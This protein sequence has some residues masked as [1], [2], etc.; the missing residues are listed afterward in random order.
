M[1]KFYKKWFTA[2]ALPAVF[3]FILV[4]LIPF[5]MGVTYSFTAWRGTYFA[6]GNHWWQAFTG[7]KNY[8]GI[9]KKRQFLDAFFYTIK[10]TAISVVMINVAGLSLALMVK[11]IA[12]G[13]GFFRSVFFLPNLLG[14]LALGFVWQFI[15]QNVYSQ[16]LF[17]PNG[18]LPI[19][20]LTNMTQNSTKALFAFAIMAVWQSAGYMMIIYLTGLNN[21][22]GELYEASAIDGAG[23]WH[24]FRNITVPLLMPSFTVVFFLTLSQSFKM[25][26]QNVAL[27]N[28]DFGTRML[29]LQILKTTSDTNPP[30]Y[31]AAQ[32]Q[33]V[34]FFILIAT[35]SLVQVYFTKKKEVEA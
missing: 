20:V 25:L 34:L 35:V 21:I 1:E 24:K 5:I 23:P 6:G 3:L 29:A 33:A 19:P 8:I 4:I 12:R 11:Q 26:D 14:G 9:F 13:K 30:D 18:L 32:A 17:G 7:L 15:F 28:G 16:T 10:Y 2:L 27:T 31:G 22:P